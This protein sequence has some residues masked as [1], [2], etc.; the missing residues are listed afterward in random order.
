MFTLPLIFQ[1]SMTVT[2]SGCS[3][4]STLLDYVVS[5]SVPSG[6]CGIS[7]KLFYNDII[8]TKSSYMCHLIIFQGLQ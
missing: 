2:V 1:I 7:H 8:S 4:V 5:F 3:T 6:L